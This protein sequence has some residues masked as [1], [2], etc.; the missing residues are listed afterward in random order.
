MPCCKVPFDTRDCR[1]SLSPVN[2]SILNPPKDITT[3]NSGGEPG[4][5]PSSWT[6]S[7]GYPNIIPAHLRWRILTTMVR[8]LGHLPL[9][10]TDYYTLEIRTLIDTRIQSERDHAFLCADCQGMLTSVKQQLDNDQSHEGDTHHNLRASASRGCQLCS[11]L[12][13][14]TTPHGVHMGRFWSLGFRHNESLPE[15]GHNAEV[16]DGYFCFAYPIGAGI[17]VDHI[18]LLSNSPLAYDMS[19]LRKIE[20]SQSASSSSTYTLPGDTANSFT[21]FFI[22]HQWLQN[23]AQT[24]SDCWVSFQDNR[25]LPSRLVDLGSTR[26][27]EPR[28]CLTSKLPSDTKYTTLSHCWGG[29]RIT[30]LNRGNL[31]DFSNRIPFRK[32]TKTFREA[33]EVTKRLGIQYIW[34]DSLCIVQGMFAASN[35]AGTFANHIT[36]CIKTLRMNGHKRAQGWL[37]FT[38]ALS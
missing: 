10:P 24:H 3:S 13:R 1:P 11:M 9:L 38:Q 34:I 16:R 15:C 32:L 31:E 14:E 22:A 20:V 29:L 26:S 33:M 12:V 18:D 36:S 25:R 5:F 2:L 23:C 6:T 17:A 7:S 30:S 27:I 19:L 35:L 28:V 37:M 21:S 8:R 4:F